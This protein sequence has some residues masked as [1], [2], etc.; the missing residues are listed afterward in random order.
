MHISERDVII[1]KLRII[2]AAYSDIL[3]IV[4]LFGSYSRGEATGQS[5]IDLYIEHNL[6]GKCL[7]SRWIFEMI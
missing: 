2:C 7:A 5:D 1:E 4:I 6:V 3:G